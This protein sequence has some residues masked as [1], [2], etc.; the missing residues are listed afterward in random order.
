MK[1]TAGQDLVFGL[2]SG[3]FAVL[4]VEKPGASVPATGETG[5][6]GGCSEEF[7]RRH[8]LWEWAACISGAIDAARQRPEVDGRAPVRIM[9]LSEG[10]ITAARL[11]R[12]RPDVSHI[13]FIS[14]FGCDQW[15][16]M[17]VIARRSAPNPAEALAAVARTEVG[18]RDIAY[19]PADP[20]RFF[21]GQTYVFWSTFGRACPAADLAAAS[22]D[23]LVAYGTADEQIDPDG[24]EAIPAARIAV[25]KPV[26]MRRI[27][28]GDHVLN[29]PG[30]APFA[31]LLGVFA[32]SLDWMEVAR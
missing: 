6:A 15:R 31:N 12:E 21:E 23:V 14:G 22:A 32:E 11:A 29:T 28:G 30:S 19:N 9:G 17:L 10:A 18:L 24:V 13:A 4:V 25:G 26:T 7:R 27:V 1:A 20:N 5:T 8:S 3:R 16:D 2:A